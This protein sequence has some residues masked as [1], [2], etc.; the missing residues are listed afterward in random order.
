MESLSFPKKMIYGTGITQVNQMN[1]RMGFTDNVKSNYNFSKDESK[2]Q[3]LIFNE[4]VV[5]KDGNS[6]T[7]TKI[8]PTKDFLNFV[9]NKGLNS[10]GL[11]AALKAYEH[12]QYFNEDIKETKDKAK[13]VIYDNILSIYNNFGITQEFISKL[14]I[15]LFEVLN[16]NHRSLV[17]ELSEKLGDNFQYV[18][19][20]SSSLD[21]IMIMY[22]DIY[23]SDSGFNGLNSLSFVD[24]NPKLLSDK[25]LAVVKF[26]TQVPQNYKQLTTKEYTKLQAIKKF[27]G[28]ISDS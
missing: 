13:E 8:T 19:F 20:Y 14:P 2:P 3:A 15:N 6:I 23:T 25:N 1:I 27:L 21:G 9:R 5:S 16:K 7:V 10:E 11:E 28:K 24:N 12:I 26:S 4:S 17:N 22:L 18:N